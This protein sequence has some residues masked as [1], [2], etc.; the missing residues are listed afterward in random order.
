VVQTT[1]KIEQTSGLNAEELATKQGFITLAIDPR[2]FVRASR[3]FGT[4]AAKN[5]R[6]T[7][8]AITYLELSA[9]LTELF[10]CRFRACVGLYGIYSGRG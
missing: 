7:K 5:C 3:G 2:L 4:L 9:A 8:N 1:V 6:F 10:S